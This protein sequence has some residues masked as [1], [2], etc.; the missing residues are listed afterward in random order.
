[1]AFEAIVV[2]DNSPDGTQ[3]AVK[4]MQRQMGA[5][6]VQLQPRS[7]KFGLGTAYSH[8]LQF[9]HCDLVA[10]MDADLSHNPKS[11][12]AM[13]KKQ[14]S[15]NADIV[16]GSRY[17]PGGGVVNWPMSRKLTSAGA[18]YLAQE[19]LGMGSF[20]SDVTGS[21][22]VYKR[23]KLSWLVHKSKATGYVFQLE[24]LYRAKQANMRIVEEP[25]C[26][27]DRLFGESKLGS[28]EIARF[29]AGL[30]RLAIT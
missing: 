12:A 29:A 7:G 28:T 18:N 19:L 16:S 3:S 2:D 17:A 6:R 15:T 30:A 27:V 24:V 4:S 21:F 11:L 10:L 5:H 1:M 22:R 13:V 25:I 20:S 14:R 23:N 8:G 26:F 9:A